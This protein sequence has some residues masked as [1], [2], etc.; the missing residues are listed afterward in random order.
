LRAAALFGVPGA[1][2][3]ALH[4][5]NAVTDDEKAAQQT[6]TRDL[7]AIAKTVATEMTRRITSATAEPA[8]NK[9]L[10]AAFGESFRVLIP[11][12][13]AAAALKQALVQG[14]TPAPTSAQM[15]EWLRISS[16][17]RAP[18]DRFHRLTMLQR[19]LT[20]APPAL[21]VTQVP[22]A[23]ST[24]WVALPFAD[25]ASRPVSG[26]LGLALFAANAI[27]AANASWSGLLLDE[28]TEL[29]P[30][31]EENTAVAFHYDDPGAEAPQAVLIAV[32]PD[33]SEQWSLETVIAVLRETLEAGKLRAVDGD[34]LGSLSQLLPATYLAVNARDDTV[35]VKF[36]NKVRKDASILGAL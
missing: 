31:R 26:T 23:P 18:L 8:A 15:R 16:L 35:S 27:P 7:V 21:T 30:S 25:E 11:F 19:A 33:N 13:P 2:V 22:Y 6:R 12:T 36:D 34:L 3:S 20:G 9:K 29:I 1:F 14:P 10:T 4:N 28:W 32:P 17:V 5:D 24:A